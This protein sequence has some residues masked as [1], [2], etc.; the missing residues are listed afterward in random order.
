MLKVAEV[1]NY[2]QWATGATPSNS[3]RLS[4]S[5]DAASFNLMLLRPLHWVIEK[6]IGED[7]VVSMQNPSPT[8][9][10]L[11]SRLLVAAEYH[12]VVVQEPFTY[13]N[14][15]FVSFAVH[16]IVSFSLNFSFLS[17]GA[18]FLPAPTLPLVV[19]FSKAMV[20]PLSLASMINIACVW[21]QQFR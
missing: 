5:S 18:S 3:N 6:L 17:F 14:H 9:I 19:T 2:D 4:R 21:I 12:T 13:E 8:R 1:L 10:M 20:V 16:C 7:Q 15:A 11:W